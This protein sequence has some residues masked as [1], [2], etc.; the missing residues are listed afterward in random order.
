MLSLLDGVLGQL[1]HCEAGTLSELLTDLHQLIN[2]HPYVQVLAGACACLTTLAGK[3]ESAARQ[4][5]SSA[6]VY[7]AWLREPGRIAGGGAGGGAGG[8][9][10]LC[11][12]L[13]ILGQL[14]RRGADLLESTAP[15]EASSVLSMTECQRIFVDYC[16]THQ[17]PGGDI[18][19]GRVGGRACG[20]LL[21]VWSRGRVNGRLHALGGR[22][23]AA[24]SSPILLASNQACPASLPLPHILVCPTPPRAALLQVAEA[25][26]GAIGMLTI[27]RPS[28]MVAKASPANQI[29]KAALAGGAPELLKL[30]ALSNLIDLLRADEERMLTAQ[31][32]AEGGGSGGGDNGGGGLAAAAAANGGAG[33]KRGGG[34]KK[35]GGAEAAAGGGLDSAAEQHAGLQ[36][37]NGMGDTLSQSSSILQDNWQAVLDLATDTSPSAA[38]GA[39]AGGSAASPP[40]SAGG[41]LAPGTH[42]RRRVVE[43]VEIVLR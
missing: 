13:F 43:L 19:V 1:K 8:S 34:G 28:I 6:A 21:G 38:G 31:Q 33:K 25:A 4:L 39:G 35:R 41:D 30:K 32:Q 22:V 37:Q 12:F 18:K 24:C 42:V 20:W 27:A 40:G 10:F 3:E 9:P 2:R 16:S 15:D 11:R 29:M 17:R 5:V 26:L 14:C 36:T 7:T 23:P